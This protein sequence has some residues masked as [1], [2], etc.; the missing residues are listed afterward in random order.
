MGAIMKKQD[1]LNLIR[2]HYD[3]NE[4]AFRHQCMQ[5]AEDFDLAGDE[6]LADF[7]ISI[8][9]DSNSF[10]PQCL[11]GG[12]D[13]L[14]PMQSKDN[15]SVQTLAFPPSIMEGIANILKVSAKPLGVNKFLFH[16]EP[17]TGKTEAVK[18]IAHRSCRDLYSIAMAQLID[19][20]LGQTAKNIDTVFKEINGVR[21]PE[22]VIILFDEIDALALTRLD[23]NDVREM[24]RATTALLKGLDSLNEKVL[25]FATTNLYSALDNALIRRFDYSLSFSQY[26]KEDLEAVA[27]SLLDEFLHTYPYAQA[28]KRLFKKVLRLFPALPNPGEM[29]NMIKVAMA[30]S[31]PE[32]GYDYMRRLYRSATGDDPVDVLKMKDQ[33]FTVREIEK[34]SSIPKSTVSRKLNNYAT[35]DELQGGDAE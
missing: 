18:Y 29:K 1:V 11:D 19:S 7:I 16:G 12:S 13:Y 5:I 17:G 35:N 6:S 15:T 21:H 32:N 23:S 26:T 28:D 22:K 9:N 30:F 24:G 10:V 14:I 20:Y 8:L 4:A 33:G 27:I 3:N 25:L 31:D 2:S 34:L